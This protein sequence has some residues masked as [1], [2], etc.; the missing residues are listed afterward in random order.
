[1][2]LKGYKERNWSVAKGM[3]ADTN[4]LNSLKNMDV[5]GITVAQVDMYVCMYV[6]IHHIL[7]ILY[8]H[9]YMHIC[10]FMYCVHQEHF[11]RTYFF[12]D[13]NR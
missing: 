13:P 6:H 1:M 3:M 4:F 8:V 9:M 7:H 12:A 2:I 5:D 11:Q 10:L